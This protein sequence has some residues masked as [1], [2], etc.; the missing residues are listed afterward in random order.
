MVDVGERARG[1]LIGFILGDSLGE[2]TRGMSPDEV[3]TQHGFVPS[4]PAEN[5]SEHLS[6]GSVTAGVDQM[7][8]TARLVKKNRAIN[9]GELAEQLLRWNENERGR[10]GHEPLE[11]GVRAGLERVRAGDKP[12]AS[13]STSESARW[14]VPL[15]I[16]HVSSDENA[17]LSNAIDA[18]CRAGSY[19]RPSVEAASLIAHTV[20]AAID[21]ET[22]GE[23]IDSAL[24]HVAGEKPCAPWSGEASVV[25]RT[26]QALDWA[27]DLRQ[28]ELLGHVQL[29]VGWSRAAGEAVPAALVLAKAFA[30]EPYRGLCAIAQLGGESSLIGSLAG[31]ILGVASGP[32]VFPERV[33]VGL[34]VEEASRLADTL[35]ARSGRGS[36]LSEVRF[37]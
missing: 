34:D 7:L 31:A 3:L 37:L 13:L 18:L 15:G 14:A 23:A 1:A 28:I 35:L 26:L 16:A 24:A 12:A 27:D 36:A 6:T 30:R 33:L 5:S 21:G 32:A 11:P 29:I 8:I 2:P 9:P 17:D 20:S 4:E 19:T 10:D 22:V 25:A